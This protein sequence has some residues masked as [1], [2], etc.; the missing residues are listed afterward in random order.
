[1]DDLGRQRREARWL[2]R[3]TKKITATGSIRFGQGETRPHIFIALQRQ[4]CGGR[5]CVFGGA[6]DYPHQN[7]RSFEAS[8]LSRGQLMRLDFIFFLDQQHNMSAL[9]RKGGAM[10]RLAYGFCCKQREAGPAKARP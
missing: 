1:M 9:Q 4:P 7:T 5:G 10:L 8:R 2:A 6:L 3:K